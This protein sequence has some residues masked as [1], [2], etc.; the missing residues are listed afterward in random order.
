MGEQPVLGRLRINPDVVG[1]GDHEGVAGHVLG[2]EPYPIILSVPEP[3]LD[4]NPQRVPRS[5]GVRNILPVPHKTDRAGGG[6]LVFYGKRIHSREGVIDEY[7][8]RGPQ[9]RIPYPGMGIEPAESY[10]GEIY[11]HLHK[12]LV[13][14]ISH[15]VLRPEIDLVHT[16]RE[17]LHKSRILTYALGNV[18]NVRWPGL[19][20]VPVH[21]EV[22]HCHSRGLIDGIVPLD[23]HL[24]VIVVV[25]GLF[26]F[27]IRQD[28]EL[29]RNARVI[30]IYLENEPVGI[31]H[32]DIRFAGFIRFGCHVYEDQLVFHL[33]VDGIDRN[34]GVKIRSAIPYVDVPGN[35]LYA[36]LHHV[37]GRY[38]NVLIR[39][40]PLETVEMQGISPPDP[41]SLDELSPP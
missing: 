17:V 21:R 29:A 22:I 35:V 1:I 16:F 26:R 24:L 39:I 23:E 25:P 28:L 12:Y 38:G 9:L 8:A 37:G 27:V 30:R 14:G 2:P 20:L 10:T 32:L 3:T 4:N 15:E 18:M 7:G 19:C 40:S 13:P 11:C 41:I 34:I 31:E 5:V 33:T 6:Y 36:Y